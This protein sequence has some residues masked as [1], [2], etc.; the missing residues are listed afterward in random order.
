MANSLILRDA[1]LISN[2]RTI[3]E[4]GNLEIP[5]HGIT[6]LEIGRAHV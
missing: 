3:F 6:A 1:K 4:S 2:E 5:L